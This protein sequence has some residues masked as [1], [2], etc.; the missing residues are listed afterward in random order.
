MVA[1]SCLLSVA[2]CGNGAGA[3]Q[4]TFSCDF[5]DPM[6]SL[7]TCRDYEGLTDAGQQQQLESDCRDPSVH[8]GVAGRWSNGLCNHDGTIG[9]C[10]TTSNGV[11]ITLWSFPGGGGTTA[12]LMNVCASAGGAF[13]SP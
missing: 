9:G 11:A 3:T 12:N 1:L 13:I 7:Y 8:G 4:G 2:G 6:M 10:R 5:R